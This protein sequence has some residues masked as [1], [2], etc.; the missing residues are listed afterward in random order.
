MI[1]A[2]ND[3]IHYLLSKMFQERKIEKY[4]QTITVGIPKNKYDS[5]VTFINRSRKDR[6]KMAVSDS[7]KKAVTNF[8][9]LIEFDF[10]SLLEVKLETGR[11]H[12]IR[13]H[14][15]HLNCPVLG[16]GTYS[17]LKRTLNPIPIHLQK[18]V[19]YLLANHLKRQAL[20][21]Y[22]LE[23]VHPLTAKEI[24]SE[25]ELPEDMKYTLGWLEQNFK[26]EP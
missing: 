26:P 5:I 17:N 13:V 20:H 7:G 10:F 15:S 16:D 12:Q 6:K 11:T 3:R 1:V 22:K 23:F 25:I 8:K 4:Y 24:K 9:I 14:L 21:S 19:K 18:K 2:K